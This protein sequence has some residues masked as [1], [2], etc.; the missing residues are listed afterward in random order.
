MITKTGRGKAHASNTVRLARVRRKDLHLNMYAEIVDA[1]TLGVDVAMLD[2]V[3][4]WR[5]DPDE[6]RVRDARASRI[7]R[8]ERLI[9]ETKEEATRALDR[10]N[11]EEDETVAQHLLEGARKRFAEARHYEE[12]LAEAQ[13][14]AA[15]AAEPEVPADLLMPLDALVT[16]LSVLLDEEHSSQPREL[17]EALRSIL[18]DFRMRVGGRDVAWE[19]YL[20]VPAVNGRVLRIGPISGRVPIIPTSRPGARDSAALVA[21]AE[22]RPSVAQERAAKREALATRGLSPESARILALHP[23]EHPGNVLAARLGISP[24]PNA[25]L[26]EEWADE[27]WVDHL[28]AAYADP[29]SSWHANAVTRASTFIQPIADRLLSRGGQALVGDVVSAGDHVGVVNLLRAAGDTERGFLP[30][31]QLSPPEGDPVRHRART[32]SLIA[33]PHCGAWVDR[34]YRLPEVTVGALCS[35]CRRMPV[36][37][38]PVF[39]R[40]YLDV[41]IDAPRGLDA[42]GLVVDEP[43]CV[44]EDVYGRWVQR[45]ARNGTHRP[46]RRQDEVL[47][48]PAVARRQ[49]ASSSEIGKALRL[50]GTGRRDLLKSLFEAGL[51]ERLDQYQPRYRLPGAGTA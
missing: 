11:K 26:S 14:E 7:R 49:G 4:D 51:L 44:V 6:L 8:L 22:G 31:F 48:L 15:G 16:A 21:L 35:T 33:C 5:A 19:T 45:A 18:Q 37:G 10:S 36:D 30:L 41:R 50:S 34:Y 47:A 29:D 3:S 42:E 39:P 25:G 27:S 46:R 24:G 28:Q 9:R 17:V 32:V 1:L 12:Q 23:L 43:D 13:R 2:G 20:L 38:S 40:E